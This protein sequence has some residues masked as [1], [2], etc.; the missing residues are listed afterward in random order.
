MLCKDPKVFLSGRKHVVFIPLSFSS[1][2]I[3]TLFEIEGYVSCLQKLGISAYRCPAL[4]RRKEW[5]Q[6]IAT[7]LKTSTLVSNDAL[8]RK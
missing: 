7:I 5:M 8:I 1:D 2:H 6:A 4:G 3:E